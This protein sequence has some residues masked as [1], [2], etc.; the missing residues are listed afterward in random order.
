MSLHL[1]SHSLCPYV[2]RAVI[3]LT[4]KNVEFKSTYIDL[5]NKPDWFLDISPLGKTPVLVDGDTPI[6]ES[7]VIL[8]YLEETQPKPLHPPT[9]LARA[10]H[11]GWIAF[12]SSI[13][14]DIAGFYSA[15]DA[16]SFEVKIDSLTEKF[17]RL[18]ITLQTGPYF[19]GKE[20]SLVDTVYGPVFRYFDVFDE[21]KEFGIMTETPKVKAWRDNLSARPSIARAV[22]LDYNEL[23]Y[24]FLQAR[25]SHL[26]EIMTALARIG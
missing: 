8:E 13:L 3:S 15:R 10:R 17:K 4:E 1:M 18:E 5:G 20:F 24:D 6:F 12:S 26:T 11:R 19:D 25:R 9:P 23:L 16:D 21:I 2:Q 22:S 14:N 7:S